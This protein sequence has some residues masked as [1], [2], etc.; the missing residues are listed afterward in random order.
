MKKV[1]PLLVIISLSLVAW[2]TIFIF[3]S[4]EGI[5]FNPRGQL[6]AVSGAGKTITAVSC[7]NTPEAPHVKNAVDQAED[8]DT[9]IVPAGTC[10][11]TIGIVISKGITLQGHT[12]VNPVNKTFNDQTIILDNITANWTAAIALAPNPGKIVRVTGFTFKPGTNTGSNGGTVHIYGPQATA[13]RVDNNHFYG[14]NRRSIFVLSAIY[15]VID[16][17]LFDF[18]PTSPYT[19][20]IMVRMGNYNGDTNGVGDKAYADYPWFGTEKFIFIEDNTFNNTS[21]TPLNGA[22]DADHGARFVIRH[23][24]FYDVQVQNHGT[25]G[26][27]RGAR[28]AEVYNNDFHPTTV[29]SLGGLRTGVY[30]FHDNTFDGPLGYGLG[31][32]NLRHISNYTNGPGGG[33]G[34]ITGD[35]TPDAGIWDVN[36]T[37]SDGT[38]VDGRAPYTFASGSFTS[39]SK[40]HDELYDLGVEGNPWSPNQW[41][42]YTVKRVSDNAIGVILSNT[43]N[44]LRISTRYTHKWA[45]GDQFEIHKALITIDQP[46]RGKGQEIIGGWDQYIKGG[47]STRN[48][49]TGVQSWPRQALE[50]CYSWNNVH[51]PS[52]TPYG[53]FAREFTPAQ[54]LVEGRDYFNNSSLNAVKAKYT[55]ELNGVDYRGPYT[56]PHPLVTGKEDPKTPAA[57][58]LSSPN[59]DT[60]ADGVTNTSDK[61]PSTPSSLRTKVN[62]HGCPKPKDSSFNIKPNFDDLDFASIASLELGKSNVGK[63]RWNESVNLKKENE[64]LNLD[65]EVKIENGK[66][67]VT[68]SEL[69]KPATITLYNITVR[70]PQ[71]LKDGAVCTGCQL[72]SYSNNTLVF[73]V[74]GFSTYEIVEGGSSTPP[75]P[76]TSSDSSRSS[77]RSGSSSRS[78]V[79]CP[80]GSVYSPT[81]GKRCTT[82]TNYSFTRDLTIGSR[83]EDVRQLQIYLNNNGFP[84]VSSGDGSKGKETTYFGPATQKALIKFQQAKKITPAAGY[85]GS[86]SRL[87]IQTN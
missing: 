30:L 66:V 45:T 76:T 23:N 16:H 72:V 51:T 19:Q 59:N 75:P 78:Q 84:I 57:P 2:L 63:I 48:S 14:T 5:V 17:N 12:T 29:T 27:V 40:I 43:S 34:G 58:S 46:C 85:F 83:G 79:I 11:W 53:F 21:G 64:E 50:P 18:D 81:T 62:K 32:A 55:A 70:N 86:K 52:G 38:Y 60:D 65:Q 41:V 68:A 20:S 15:G 44:T 8:G 31:F 1:L 39:I 74:P 28:A 26:R 47:G 24:H 71:F 42:G 82:F 3:S 36:A 54:I 22:L 49:V 87:Y 37:E 7:N 69:N 4:F 9:V 77:S 10:S 61:C 33:F 73:T 6:G 67:T 56:Y 13:A 80:K 25:E 35:N